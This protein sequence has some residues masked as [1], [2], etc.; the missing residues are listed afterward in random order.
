MVSSGHTSIESILARMR[1]PGEADLFVLGC[2]ERPATVYMQQVRALN[3][4]YALNAEQRSAGNSMIVIG[5]GAGGLTAAAAAAIHGWRVTVIDE[6]GNDVLSLAGAVASERWLHPRIYDW[7]AIESEENATDLGVLDWQAGPADAVVEQLRQRWREVEHARGIL[8]HLGVTHVSVA[9]LGRQYLVQW[10]G[11]GPRGAA[12]SR[13]RLRGQRAD[14]VILAVG[15][16]KEEA[17]AELPCVTSYWAKDNIDQNKTG[18]SQTPLVLVSGT[19]D[20]GLIDVLRYSFNKFKHEDVVDYLQRRWLGS[21]GYSEVKQRL[22]VIE[23]RVR[24]ASA[25]GEPYLA[26]LNCSYRELVDSLTLHAPISLRQ[27][28]EVV[29]TGTRELPLSLDA[30]PINRFLFSLTHAQYIPGPLTR[31]EKREGRWEVWFRDH[32]TSHS[33]HELVIRHGPRPALARHF[34]EIYR[35]CEPLIQAAK[36]SPDPTREP[37][38]DPAFKLALQAASGARSASRTDVGATLVGASIDRTTEAALDAYRAQ[39]LNASPATATRALVRRAFNYQREGERHGDGDG[40][41]F[42]VIRGPAGAGKTTEL[43]FIAADAARTPAVVPVFVWA[44]NAQ[45]M[46][47]KP[48]FV[49]AIDW[50]LASLDVASGLDQHALRVALLERMLQGRLLVLFDGLDELSADSRSHVSRMIDGDT[51][52]LRR[53]NRLIVTTRPLGDLH[54]SARAPVEVWDIAPPSSAELLKRFSQSGDL[55]DTRARAVLERLALTTW[56]TLSFSREVLVSACACVDERGAESLAENVLKLSVLRGTDSSKISFRYRGMQQLLAARALSSKHSP[57]ELIA[58]ELRGTYQDWDVVPFALAALDTPSACFALLESLPES[59]DLVVLRLRLRA[60]RCGVVATDDELTTLAADVHRTVSDVEIASLDLLKLVADASVG[61]PVAAEA[62]VVARLSLLLNESAVSETRVRA[63]TWLGA[64]RCRSASGAV[65]PQLRDRDEKI[66]DAAA[67]TLGEFASSD[68]IPVL[69]QAYLTNAN[70][71]VF[72][73]AVNAIA[74][75]GGDV[76]LEGLLAI[77]NDHSLFH[78]HRWPAAKCLGALGD[79]RALPSL[80]AVST[81]P[82]EAVRVHATDALGR[83]DDRRAVCALVKNLRDPEAAVR[84]AAARGLVSTG[85]AAEVPALLDALDDRHPLVAAEAARAL[86]RLDPEELLAR[87]PHVIAERG[88]WRASAVELLGELLGG[89]ALPTL[90]TLAQ[91]SDSTIRLG[92]ARALAHQQD[93]QADP[94]LIGL[95][96]DPSKAVRDV[97][98]EALGARQVLPAVR[99]IAQ[100][101]RI[102]ASDDYGVAASDALGELIDVNAALALRDVVESDRALAAVAARSLARIARRVDI[103]ALPSLMVAWRKFAQGPIPEWWLPMVAISIGNYGGEAAVATLRGYVLAGSVAERLAVIEGLAVMADPS[104]IA[105]LLLL[106]DDAEISVRRLAR[107]A[108]QSLPQHQIG[109][110]LFAALRDGEHRVLRQAIIWCP[111]YGDASTSATLD[112]TDP[113]P[114]GPDGAAV[115][116]TARTALA[117]RRA[118]EG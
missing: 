92:A 88:V 112:S 45:V 4:V 102:D 117:H 74:T 100:R 108:L 95:V 116:A 5:A 44:R 113:A 3:L 118:L 80:V 32:P 68:L 2:F 33:F 105:G 37:C 89:G 90:S 60:V 31:I 99:A 109:T 46:V 61:L 18:A 87:I 15:F 13:R 17:T 78:N 82:S 10:N 104:A 20:G 16:G 38:F 28:V 114:L 55:R 85:K 12:Q 14:V 76:A 96:D 39:L 49:A 110:G 73:A 7:P 111:F 86:V 35:R 23:N 41:G 83:F 26:D 27:D 67:R 106:V 52:N 59:F 84:I 66:R 63:L 30:A 11:T 9:P 42:R 21:A 40:V 64:A 79:V 56:S 8:T 75:I 58:Q 81:D 34:P 98:I 24:A 6:I 72:T 62:I 93:S 1:V 91:D 25:A 71:Y 51:A 43:R 50:C 48:F 29:V 103:D 36:A 115:I 77:L 69:V 47:D 94:H 65:A 22:A 97:A 19:G 70:D 101:L 107:A 57:A 54:F 53:G